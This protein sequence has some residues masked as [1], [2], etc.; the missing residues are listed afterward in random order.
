MG[1]TTKPHVMLFHAAKATSPLFPCLCTDIKRTTQEGTCCLKTVFQ[2]IKK[3]VL[4]QTKTAAP[5]LNVY[6]PV[7]NGH[8]KAKGGIF[9][10]IACF[11]V[12]NLLSL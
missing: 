6:N 8:P 4:L 12:F 3:H 1:P 9:S 10:H 7:K 2:K 11:S 5:L